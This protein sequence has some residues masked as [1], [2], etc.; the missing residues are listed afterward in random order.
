MLATISA[1]ELIGNC[2]TDEEKKFL[3]M[4]MNIDFHHPTDDNII[5]FIGDEMS[6]LIKKVVN[7]FES[8]NNTK[9]K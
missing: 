8:C 7:P 3:L 9:S 5:I 6:H 1:E 2:F 4:K